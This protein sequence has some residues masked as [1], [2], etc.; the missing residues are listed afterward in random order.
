MIVEIHQLNSLKHDRS[1]SDILFMHDL[2]KPI[3]NTSPD[4][5]GDLWLVHEV[6]SLSLVIH[7]LLKHVTKEVITIALK[8]NVIIKRQKC[9][10]LFLLVGV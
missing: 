9:V 5:P 1:I 2:I 4:L 6:I 3:N 10:H 7:L 8:I